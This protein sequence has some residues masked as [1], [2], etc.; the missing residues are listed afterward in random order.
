[1]SMGGL[2]TQGELLNKNF[3]LLSVMVLQKKEAMY[4]KAEELCSLFGK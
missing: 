4:G 3:L 1:M 2:L